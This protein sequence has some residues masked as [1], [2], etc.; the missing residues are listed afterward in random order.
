MSLS[1]DIKTISSKDNIGKEKTDNYDETIKNMFNSKINNA[2]DKYKNRIENFEIQ[3]DILEIEEI[4]HTSLYGQNLLIEGE[5]Y[6]S[7]IYLKKH[8]QNQVGIIYIDPPYSH[9]KKDKS[10]HDKFHSHN[11]WIDMM[12]DRLVIAKDLLKVS[13]VIFISISDKEFTQLKLVCDALFGEDNFICNFTRNKGKGTGNDANH[14]AIH[15]DYILCYRKTAENKFFNK[16]EG[17]YRKEDKHYAK[18][19]RYNL[20]K[21]ARSKQSTEGYVYEIKL[22]N[23]K[24]IKPAPGFNWKYPED[25]YLEKKMDGYIEF[26]N[27]KPYYK[28]YEK[29]DRHGKE[30]K[31][32]SPYG[33]LTFVDKKYDYRNANKDLKKVFNKVPFKHAKPIELVKDI[34]KIAGSKEVI[35]LDFFAGSGTT[36]VAILELNKDDGGKRSFILCTNNEVGPKLQKELENCGIEKNTEEYNKNGICRKVCLP[37]LKFTIKDDNYRHEI[38]DTIKEESLRKALKD[39]HKMLDA[40][41]KQDSNNLEIIKNKIKNNKFYNIMTNFSDIEKEEKSKNGRISCS[42][43]LEDNKYKLLRKKKTVN[44]SQEEGIFKYKIVKDKE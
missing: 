31:G 29:E 39:A 33:S 4:R 28:I 6:D 25:S 35:V 12:I 34:V 38:I 18:K 43:E 16:K 27:D 2:M 23:G 9:E 42:R 21:L 14:I 11:N 10:H 26:K 3:K 8:Y 5:N 32:T 36:G 1:E 41:I 19:G 15:H 17:Q 7:L 30:K 37:R 22:E 24:K 44:K 20:E 13:G 40:V